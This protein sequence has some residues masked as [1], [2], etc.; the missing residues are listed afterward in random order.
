V[1]IYQWFAEVCC[2]SENPCVDGS[3]PPPGTS[4]KPASD[5]H[6][7]AFSI[8]PNLPEI[9]PKYT[10]CVPN[11]AR[12]NLSV[13]N[14][15]Q[16]FDTQEKGSHRFHGFHKNTSRCPARTGRARFRAEWGSTAAA[17]TVRPDPIICGFRQSQVRQIPLL[18]AL[19][20]IATRQLDLLR[21]AGRR[22]S[23]ARH[24]LPAS[25]NRSYFV[26]GPS[27]PMPRRRAP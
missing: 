6:L 16:A 14:S 26:C 24:A 2:R 10:R 7:R 20:R 4:S 12:E 19:A 11:F 17:R 9:P 3:I 5:K 25:D 8:I 13:T 15:N 23:I 22:R 18:N 1:A 27:L 21:P